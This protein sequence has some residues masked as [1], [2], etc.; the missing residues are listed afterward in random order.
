MLPAILSIAR[1]E[2]FGPLIFIAVIYAILTFIGRAQKQQ[3]ENA[4]RGKQLPGARGTAPARPTP[5]ERLAELTGSQQE[6]YTLADLLGELTGAKTQG[7]PMG[8]PAGRPLPSAEEAEERES[9]E[10][11]P[12]VVSRETPPYRPLRMVDLDDSVEA[13]VQARID[14]A[15]ARNRGLTAADHRAFDKR[16]RAAADQTVVVKA[17]HRGRVQQAVIWKEI[18]DKPVALRD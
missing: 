3:K 4:R 18:L 17:R 14:A 9:L 12:V 11:E 16:I 1:A 7:G 8:R 10:T 13:V 5:K 6:G 2:G 15:E